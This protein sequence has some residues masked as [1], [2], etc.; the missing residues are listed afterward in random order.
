MRSF[1]SP[2]R[3]LAAY[4]P[5]DVLAVLREVEREAAAGRVAIGC[6]AYE[7][8]PAFDPALCVH[9]PGEL[10]LAWFAVFDGEPES[11]HAHPE[12]A[13]VS[14]LRWRPAVDRSAYRAALDRVR[15]WIAAGDTYQVN[16]T[17]STR[18]DFH[19]DAWTFFQSM[20]NAQPTEFGAY[21]DL[22]RFAIASVS[23]ELFFRLDGDRI[24]TRPMKG[25]AGRGLWFADDEQ[26][27]AALRASPKERAENVMIVD[28]IRNDLGRIAR[29]GSVE[30][31]SLF[32]TERH[33]T[34]WQMTST[35]E[36]R[37]DA[38]LPEIF[39][40]LFP[41]ASVTGAPKVRTMEI[42]RELETGPRGV[43]C[44]AI[45]W[46]GPGRRAQ[47]SVGIR[48]ATIDRES[49]TATYH[50]GSGITWDSIVEAEQD[51]CRLKAGVLRRCR[52]SF[53]LLESLRWEGGF[54]R[55]DRHLERLRDS[56]A[57]FAFEF[58]E[59]AIRA[60]LDERARTLQEPSKVR[61]LLTR[62]GRVSVEAQPLATPRVVRLGVASEPIDATDVFLYHKTTRRVVYDNARVMRPDCDDVILWNER[63]EVTESSIANV[64]VRHGD[65][66]FT[67]PVSAGLLPGVMRG[68][69]LRE[70]RIR[71]SRLPLA[72]LHAADEI[73][74]VNSVR[75]WMPASLSDAATPSAATA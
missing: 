56:A 42:I 20:A 53:D 16:Y 26:R 7:A 60:A 37:T 35:V 64:C 74:L 43:Y 54:A 29:V 9:A 6:V 45:G 31:A 27:A 32:D 19:G 49:R 14:A 71:E 33:P 23:P 67:P 39:Q 5:A 30:V 59:T 72:D 50:V 68:E 18:A 34:V 13:P 40:A 11:D 48:T 57:Y 17:Y 51:E 75:G 3:E 62:R 12:T 22:G 63:G 58:D 1:A 41:S 61:L 66:W 4:S 70:G 73:A 10:P 25:T 65:V 8:A 15:A 46:V 44:G 2:A 21:L 36:A 47:F 24:V 28:M 55:L 69:L 52:P 38:A